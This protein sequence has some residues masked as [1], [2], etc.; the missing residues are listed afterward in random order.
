[1]NEMALL[2]SLEAVA[3]SGLLQLQSLVKLRDVQG[4]FLQKLDDRKPCWRGKRFK[5]IAIRFV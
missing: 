2:Q 5:E 1:M 3:D 4:F